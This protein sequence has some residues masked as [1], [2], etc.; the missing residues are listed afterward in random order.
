MGKS[1]RPERK[2]EDSGQIP[3]S[4]G[5]CP[6]TE[7]HGDILA[8]SVTIGFIGVFKTKKAAQLSGF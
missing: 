1:P 3:A 2:R 7:K 6:T 4:F 5:I 8:V